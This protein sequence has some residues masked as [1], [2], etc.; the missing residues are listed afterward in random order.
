M[1][2]L[3]RRAEA[4]DHPFRALRPDEAR[5][6]VPFSLKAASG[7]AQTSPV[8]GGGPPPKAEVD[9]CGPASKSRDLSHVA[10]TLTPLRVTTARRGARVEIIAACPQARAQGIRPGMALTAARASVPGI[11]AHAADPEGDAHAL[12]RLAIA[13]ARRFSPTVAVEGDDTLLIDLTG[14]AHLFGGE[15]AMAARLVRL[16]ARLGHRARIAIADTP[17]AAWALAHF[18]APP[19]GDAAAFDPPPPR[20]AGLRPTGRIRHPRH[21]GPYRRTRPTTSSLAEAQGS[22][23]VPPRAQADALAP[24]PLAALRADAADLELLRRLGVEHVGQLA[25]MPRAPIARR[26]A[27]VLHRL[28]QAL[29]HLPEP[30]DPVIPREAILCRQGFLEPIGTAEAI[31]HWLGV[32]VPQLC[33]ALATQ[34]MGARAVE[35]VAERVDHVPQRLRIGLARASRDPAHLLR[36]IARRIDEIEPGYGIDAMALHVRRAEPLG[37]QELVERLDAETAPDLAPLVDAIANRIGMARLWRNRAVESDVPERSVAPAPP[38]D[39]AAP[40]AARLHADDVRRLDRSAPPGAWHPRWHRP[41]RLLRRPERLDDVMALLPDHAPMRFTWRGKSYRVA[42]ADGP[43]RIHGEWWR[44]GAERDA[45]R[46]YF[47]VED[48]A[49]RRFWLYRRGD[50]ERTATGDLSW[51]L[52]GLFG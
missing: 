37:P 38:L 21:E 9:G 34:G 43:E 30:L 4:A 35:L 49:G 42:R 26:F 33:A 6:A 7:P 36:L 23:I 18:G 27:R 40:P 12:H 19:A 28:D 17:G 50:G 16:M 14:V 13:L 8:R 5:G 25:A 22:V 44:R 15:A 3:G 52:H 48:D 2:E 45:V 1:R 10:E 31:A 47:R 20:H 46:D 51:W 24:L 29:G 39:T 11:E 41:P 32:L